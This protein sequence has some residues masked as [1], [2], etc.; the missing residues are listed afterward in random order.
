M[1]KEYAALQQDFKKLYT[2]HEEL[3]GTVNKQQTVIE[4]QK[5]LLKEQAKNIQDL[6]QD[7][8]HERSKLSSPNE[9]ANKIT[10]NEFKKVCSHE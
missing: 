8:E 2:S 1:W 10:L 7:N 6:L 5:K 3:K 4:N 9:D